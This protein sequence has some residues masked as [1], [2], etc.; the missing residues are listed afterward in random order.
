M[1]CQ[2][3]SRT[4][5]RGSVSGGSSAESKAATLS[6]ATRFAHGP[7]FPL[8][9]WS[10]TY[11]ETR[12]LSGFLVPSNIVLSI[13]ELFRWHSAQRISPLDICHPLRPLHK[14]HRNLSGQA[15]RSR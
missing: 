15:S 12:N 7:K 8:N 5:L 10:A 11:H 4:V 13:T 3:R 2:R 6:S 9:F 14:G 1:P